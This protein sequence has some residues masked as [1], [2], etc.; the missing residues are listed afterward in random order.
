MKLSHLFRGKELYDP[1]NQSAVG[2]SESTLTFLLFE[3]GD[4]TLS[5]G[6]AVFL[7]AFYLT[8]KFL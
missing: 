5:E 7:S 6:G 1:L 2:V 3:C 8:F 4:V